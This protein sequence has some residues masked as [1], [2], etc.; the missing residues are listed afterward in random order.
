MPIVPVACATCCQ[1]NVSSLLF[2]AGVDFLWRVVLDMPSK[3]GQL[4]TSS[5]AVVRASQELL[6]RLYQRQDNDSPVP[7]QLCEHF[8]RWAMCRAALSLCKVQIMRAVLMNLC[9]YTLSGVTCTLMLVLRL[10]IKSVMYFQL[11]CDFWYT[12]SQ[13][14][15][16]FYNAGHVWPTS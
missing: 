14:H 10:A 15:V 6:I 9:T 12:S 1:L 7:R 3:K 4:V 2:L 11:V 16:C 5:Q 8:V 13:S